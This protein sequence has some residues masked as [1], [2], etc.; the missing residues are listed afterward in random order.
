MKALKLKASDSGLSY[1]SPGGCQISVVMISKG[2][3]DTYVSAGDPV[4]TNPAGTVGVKFFDEPGCGDEL[5]K[6]LRT[7]K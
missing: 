3:V 6:G 2:Q 1:T 4:A 7:L 5:A